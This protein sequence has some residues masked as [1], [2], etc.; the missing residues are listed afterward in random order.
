[1]ELLVEP[2]PTFVNALFLALQLTKI[3]QQCLS[4]GPGILIAARI[5]PNNRY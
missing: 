5:R 2:A 4:L 1:M 3:S